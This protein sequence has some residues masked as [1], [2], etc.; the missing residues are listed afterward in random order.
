MLLKQLVLM[1]DA[2]LEYRADI[3]IVNEVHGVTLDKLLLKQ[4][5]LTHKALPECLAN[6]EL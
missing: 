3:E 5:P 6:T 1:R 2:L 4:L